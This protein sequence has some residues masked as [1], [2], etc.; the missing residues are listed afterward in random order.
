MSGR[1]ILFS[2]VIIILLLLSV[3]D[4][5]R[6]KEAACAVSPGI[7]TIHTS[8]L[9][10]GFASQPLSARPAVYWVW[11]NGL[12][13]KQQLTYE[14]QQMRAKGLG[15]VYIFDVSAHD[16]K[17]IVPEGPAFMGPESLKAIGHAAREAGR[18]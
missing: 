9:S 5:A 8:N 16:P 6:A 12:R 7:A 2:S 13:N 3:T 10:D 18:L 17:G 14:L 11:V 1:S 15:G 4:E